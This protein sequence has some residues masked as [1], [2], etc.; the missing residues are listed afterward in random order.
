MAGRAQG[1]EWAVAC[2]SWRV[3][4]LGQVARPSLARLWTEQ[5][6]RQVCRQDYPMRILPYLSN[7]ASNFTRTGPEA[8]PYSVSKYL[9]MQFRSMRKTPSM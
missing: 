5:W 9:L 7:A 6:V 3:A 1:Q 8:L 2:S 4:A